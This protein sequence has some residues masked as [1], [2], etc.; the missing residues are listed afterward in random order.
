MK[1][2]YF[3]VLVFLF[4]FSSISKVQF[5]YK[6]NFVRGIN[7]HEPQSTLN[8]NYLERI[9]QWPYGSS[10]SVAVDSIRNI[11]FLGSGGAV[12]ILDGTDK[13]NPQLITDTIRTTGLVE[14][15]FYDLSTGRLYLACGEG[16]YEI[17]NVENPSAPFLYSR[18]EVLYGGAE[19]P[20]GHVQVRGD[21]AVFECSW[22]EINSVNISDP[23]HPYKVDSDDYVGNPA[24]NIHIDPSGRVHATG[25]QNYVIYQLDGSGHLIRAGSLPIGDCNAVFGG[26]QASYVGQEGRL[27]IINY[28]G[29]YNY[30][31]VAGGITST[32]EVRGNL[33]YFINDNGLQI[34]DVSDYN[35]PY[36][37]G[38]IAIDI[39]PEDLAV[40]GHYAYVSNNYHGLKIYDVSNPI[41]PQLV[42][43][44]ET[45]SV[46]INIV[47]KDSI[48]Y[49]AH[50]DDGLLMI[51]VSNHEY[52]ILIGQYG[53]S[54][55]IY[56]VKIKDN[57]AFLTGY[58]AGFRIVD[59]SNPAAP[60]E[61][62]I[63]DNMQAYMLEISENYAYVEE[64]DPPNTTALIRIYD[65]T[66]PAN[67]VEQGNI[68]IPHYSH[69]FPYYNGYLFVADFNEGLRILNVTDPKNPYE[70]TSIQ[71]PDVLDL[72]LKDNDAYICADAP[73]QNDGGLY[74]YDISNPETPVEKGYYSVNGF[75]PMDVSAVDS[76]AYVGDGNDIWLF[77]L[78]DSD[79]IFIDQFRFPDLISDMFPLGK[80]LYVSDSKAGLSI[81]KNTLI[82][83]PVP[84]I[85]E[86]QISGI[87]RNINAVYFTSLTNGWAVADGGKVLHTT[88][89]GENWE[90]IQVG[91][92]YLDDF[93]DL[94]FTDENTGWV[95]GANSSMFKT[96]NGG[97]NWFQLNVPTSSI[98]RSMSFLNDTLGWVVTLSDHLILKTTNGGQTWTQQ[99]SGLTGNLHHLNVFFTDENNGFIT[100]II[101]A[102][103]EIESYIL[104]T[105]NRG[106]IWT[107]NFDFQY[108][109][110]DPIFF[111]NQN[112]GWIGGANGLLIKTTD[113]GGYWQFQNT[114]T[115]EGITHLFF[116]NENEGWLTGFNATLDQT[117]DGG[118][119][120]LQHNVLIQD[121]LRSVYFV[122]ETNGWAVGD[123]GIILHTGNGVV[124]VDLTS[125]TASVEGN[126][127]LFKWSTTT[128]TNNKGFEIERASSESLRNTPGQE[129]WEKIGFVNG[130]GTTTESKSYSFVD[131]NVSSGNY[132]YRLKQIDF[133]GT[134]KYSK[135]IEVS[136]NVPVEFSL[137]QNY[138]N[139]FNPTTTIE[140]SIPKDGMVNLTVFNVLGQRVAELINENMK[141]GK[142]HVFFDAS[143][144]ASG[145]YYYRLKSD[146]KVK[147]K[148][149][150]I[151]K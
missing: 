74:I 37:L 89:G 151:L 10:L 67:P 43:A 109:D 107:S 31:F 75:T 50:D 5:N 6:T 47:V 149:M 56:D 103:S 59:V 147:V 105:T 23:Y 144:L 121:V 95:C 12:L 21:F 85:W 122:D 65:I 39:F 20:V 61:V 128:E 114:G 113:G 49:V 93:M 54:I 96:T 139:P 134:F 133:N 129:V 64:F 80:Y 110:L 36:Y 135:E 77:Y 58:Q 108:Q 48:A 118:N 16:G 111:V 71:M 100:G 8:T 46:S 26:N 4:S 82:E 57:L 98:I 53:A 136:I 28:G 138:P 119:S 11:I 88:D 18:N 79:P 9:G 84:R 150:I 81:Y 101:L 62:S 51:D 24:H 41:E 38:S 72:Y 69:S 33:A 22:G 86:F 104:K 142:Y 120:W 90:V 60:V 34:W 102:G 63:V 117:I 106:Q 99:N 55:N 27:W 140:Y 40:A 132:T 125:F 42:G 87:T 29:G 141:T 1:K 70:V 68:T 17:W 52:P 73:P 97:Q 146:D 66:N 131:N 7:N 137:Q 45:Y 44:Y 25:V 2:F 115:Y 14:D 15:I 91:N 126:N 143:K 130:N 92:A 30:T 124:P 76:F 112:V 148:K 19:T 123:N 32:I 94:T 145:V 13:T 35:N 78:T 83:D 3:A 116:N 127:V